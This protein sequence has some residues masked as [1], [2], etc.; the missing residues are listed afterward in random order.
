ME[1]VREEERIERDRGNPIFFEDYEQTSRSALVPYSA[2]PSRARRRSVHIEKEYGQPAP[3]PR[4]PPPRP[5]FIR[6]Q[7]SLD[8]FDRRPMP[9]F[10]D[11]EDFRQVVTVPTPPRRRRSPVRRIDERDYEEVRIVD[12]EADVNIRHVHEDHFDND[13]YYHFEQDQ[14]EVPA[15][16]RER[17]RTTR[18]YRFQVDDDLVD[19][20][21]VKRGKTR[22]PRR[23]VE[24]TAIDVLGYPFEEEVSGKDVMV[25]RDI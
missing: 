5:K 8:T 18:S 6:R 25:D 15:D 3:A 4:G 20:P 9:R 1:V 22:V 16:V 10:G 12:Q 2:G 7:S 23:L 17:E 11:R 19:A 21:P 24:K 13:H 14:Y